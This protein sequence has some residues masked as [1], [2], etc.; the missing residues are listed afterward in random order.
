MND[1]RTGGAR[2]QK[3]FD[4]R[5][6]RIIRIRRF[7]LSRDWLR[8]GKRIAGEPSRQSASGKQETLPCRIIGIHIPCGHDSPVGNAIEVALPTI[9]DGPGIVPRP[10]HLDDDIIGRSKNS[11]CT[12]IRDVIN[13][14]AYRAATVKTGRRNNRVRT[15]R[16]VIGI[17][18]NAG[19]SSH[20]QLLIG[21]LGQQEHC[22]ADAR[23]KQFTQSGRCY[24]V[25]I[26]CTSFI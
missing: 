4:Q 7:A 5:S 24:G 22:N 17:C 23:C 19:C 18:C 2:H 8:I 3:S 12:R 10:S 13:F 14:E 26:Q 11:V 9:R 1:A 20:R 25:V 21:R 15:R 6:T 16:K